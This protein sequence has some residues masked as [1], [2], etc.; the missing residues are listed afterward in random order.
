MLMI[1][2]LDSILV[3]HVL[4]I[5]KQSLLCPQTEE[6]APVPDHFAVITPMHP[7][8]WP[9][10]SAELRKLLEPQPSL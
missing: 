3:I 8:V 6:C 7:V 2:D 1:K 9:R 10:L 5:D 4:L